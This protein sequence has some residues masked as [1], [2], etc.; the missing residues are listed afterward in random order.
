MSASAGRYPI[1]L[2][3]SRR[4][5]SG[6][7]GGGVVEGEQ[8]AALAEQRVGALGDVPELLP[9][10]GCFGVEGGGFGVVAG[11]FGELGAGGAERVLA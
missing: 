2:N 1:A 8:A 9:A 5:E 7:S 3:S 11:V 10:C 6:S 4:L